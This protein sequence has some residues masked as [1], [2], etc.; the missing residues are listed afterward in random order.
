MDKYDEPTCVALNDFTQDEILR[1]CQSL[2]LGKAPGYDSITYEHFKYAGPVFNN[3]LTRLFNSILGLVHIPSCFK[4]GLLIT[5]YKGHGKPKDHKD[6][7]R[8][9]T[10]LPA[11]N[12]ILEKCIMSRMQVHL[13]RI[14][15]PPP[16][17]HASRPGVNNVMASFAANE[18]ITY[19]TEKGGK[20]FACFLDI[21]KCFD[22]L[23]W[24]GLMY[25]LHKIG[26][27]N[28]LWHLIMDWMIGS[29][30]RVCVNGQISQSFQISRSIKQG[31]ILSMLNLCIFMHD[32]HEYI[33][34]FFNLGL[35][36]SNIYAGSICY[37]DDILL[38]SPS[39]EGLDVMMHKAWTFSRIWRFTFSIKK[40]N[41]MVFGETKLRN[42]RNAGRR[43]FTLGDKPVAEVTHYNHLG[44]MLC[45][46]GSSAERTQ[47]ACNKGTKQLATLKPVGAVHSKLYPST[48]ALLWN[49]ICIPAILHGSEVWYNT[50]QYEWDLLEKTQ[51]R[52][53]RDVQGLSARTHNSIA[54]GLIGQLSMR[55]LIYRMKLSF[56]QRL[57]SLDTKTLVKR[58]F[59]QR[60]Y[61]SISRTPISGFIYDILQILDQYGL[62]QY[63]TTYM[64]GGR[65]PS[66]PEWK[67]TLKH[68]I[69]SKDFDWS[70]QALDPKTDCARYRRSM[71]REK[72]GSMHQ[73]YNMA[74]D[75]NNVND[76]RI[77]M[78]MVRIQSVPDTRYDHAPCLS[79]GRHYDDIICHIIAQC[80]ALYAERNIMWDYIIDNSSVQTSV[81]IAYLDD[82]GFIDWLWSCKT[83]SEFTVG[84]CKIVVQQFFKPLKMNYTWF[85]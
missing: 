27:D 40:S 76:S 11:I 66:K 48:S 16:L 7:Y 41:C 28:K 31:G 23:W 12:K 80:P 21:E 45:A 52:A 26:I 60:L 81:H 18:A 37:A 83:S 44:V 49:S 75:T 57:I 51:C 61:E 22:K 79:C 63:L 38:M 58:I 62:K 77:L 50:K 71:D 29:N 20:V 72:H 67:Q 33:D 4:T 69:T 68:S 15:F 64:C 36:C 10:L 42:S 19:H 3:I 24:S 30:C 17:Q 43:Q 6:S 54:R 78:A 74:K 32:I 55:S 34:E 8:G 14:G 13:N 1:I 39:K 85:H 9:V 56:L 65:F 46:Y 84:L 35:Y 73:L 47:V 53:L 2:P 59:L 25:K 82:S 70:N 5:I